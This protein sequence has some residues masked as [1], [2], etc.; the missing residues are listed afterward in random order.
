MKKYLQLNNEVL[1]T[2]NETQYIDRE[3]DAQATKEYFL[4]EVNTNFRHYL[5]LR[6]KLNYLVR[7]GYYEPDFLEMYKFE[8]IKAVFK[9]A[10]SYKFRFPS[11]MSASKFYDGYAMKDR[12]GK[13]WLEKYEDR[14]AMSGLLMAMGD[15]E[16]AKEFVR[17]MMEVY[18]PATPT[19]LNLGKKAR[20]EFV[21]CFKIGADDSMNAIGKMI[22]DALRLSKLGGG[23]GIQ[24]T[25][26]RP[27]G[28]PIKGIENRASGI[29]PVAKLLENSFSYAN[30]LGQR[31]GSGVIYLNIFHGDILQ[32]LSAKKPNADEKIQLATLSTGLIIPDI[33]FRKM[34]NEEDIYL[35][36]PYDIKKEYGISMSDFDFTSRYQELVDNPN[37]RKLARISATKLYNDVKKTQ[38]ESGYPFEMYID[39]V[40]EDHPLKNMG[41]VRMSN[42]CTEILQ[43]QS[44]TVVGDYDEDDEVGFDVSCNLGSIDI[45]NAVKQDDF[46]K[47]I[48]NI[49]LMLNYVS[50]NSN[51]KVES[52]KKGNDQF[53]SIGL[54]VMN[55]HGHLA[56]SDIQYGSDD[57]LTFVDKFY[58]ALNFYSIKSS[59]EIAKERGQKFLGFEDSAY[60]TGE[61]FDQYTE[62][63][64][65]TML[66]DKVI[67]AMGNVP[68]VTPEMWRELKQQVITHGLYNAYRLAIA[69]TG[70]ISYI[71]SCT[72]S[73]APITEK[74]E[75]RDY[76]KSRTIYPMPFLT[77][78]NEHLFVSAYDM[79]QYEMI[80]MYATAQKHIDQGISMTLYI[81]DQ[82]NTEELAKL[83]IYAWKKGI[84]TVYYVRQRTTKI[85]ECVACTI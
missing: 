67:T 25:D 85:E 77:K 8:D 60:G 50:D 56:Y 84:K 31:Q 11:F 46:G 13:N 39:T 22:D 33:F 7:E 14:I 49:N 5:T 79:D 19:F 83:Y 41:K 43:V 9:I 40:N 48:K 45:H 32:F 54:G 53:H 1:T 36:S 38:I 59:M 20:G 28:D 73:M 3:K 24:L 71:R 76:D 29:I 68:I 61:Y 6:E 34:E 58:E 30:Q 2:Y 42:L 66:S 12:E 64:F 62:S 55:L 81:T 80:D 4:S 44:T 65:E 18:Q 70:S 75:V 23:V 51:I 82:W 27:A 78:E 69:P 52:I 57:A 17:N 26:L 16:L 63:K 47:M 35:F 15:A 21:S 10:Y 72:A 37:I 74:V